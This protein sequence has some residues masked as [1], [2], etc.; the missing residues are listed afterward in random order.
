M[1]LR[2]VA[3]D[4]WDVLPINVLADAVQDLASS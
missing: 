3:E 1:D 4:S 2:G